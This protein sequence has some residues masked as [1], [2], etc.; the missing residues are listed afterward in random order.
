MR[1]TVYEKH[2]MSYSPEYSIWEDMIDRC[3]NPNNV[4]YKHYGEKGITICEDWLRF[5]KFYEDMGSRPDK[6]TL[7]RIDNDKGYSKDN[8]RWT[9]FGVQN[10]N[11]GPKST[12]NT[13]T[14]GVGWREDKQRYRARIGINGKTIF[15]GYYKELQDAVAARK[16]AEGQYY[17]QLE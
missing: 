13:G 2:G 8:C 6:L 5:T 1:R 12:N 4:R 9:T 15:L 14:T 17:Q 3:Y 11:R 7:D 16:L 10:F